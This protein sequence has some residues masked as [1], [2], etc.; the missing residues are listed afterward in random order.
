[1]VATKKNPLERPIKQM[2]EVLAEGLHENELQWVERVGRSLEVL[3]RA[4][5][6]HVTL[7]ESPNGALATLASPHQDTVA[8]LD[9]RVKH[10]RH[11]H[12]Q[13]LDDASHLALYIESIHDRLLAKVDDCE[14]QLDVELIYGLAL[15]ILKQLEEHEEAETKLFVQ[16]VSTDECGAGD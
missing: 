14:A 10:L 5:R 16:V 3:L 2:R 9:R 8:T 1:M 15:E 11:E 6:E 12:V 13:L 4:I 7:A